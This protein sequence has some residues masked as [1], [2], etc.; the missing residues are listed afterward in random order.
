MLDLADTR[1][2]YSVR[3]CKC[4][5]CCITL[6]CLRLPSQFLALRTTLNDIGRRYHVSATLLRLLTPLP[7]DTGI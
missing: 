3:M 4:V 5:S 2:A 7:F 6:M 1:N